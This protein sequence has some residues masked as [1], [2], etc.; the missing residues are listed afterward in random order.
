MIHFLFYHFLYLVFFLQNY[1]DLFS[2]SYRKSSE[3]SFENLSENTT[4]TTFETDFIL[5]VELNKKYVL[6]YGADLKSN[7]FQLFPDSNYSHL[8]LTRLKVGLKI[9]YSEK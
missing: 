1:I 6:I 3:T 8:Y 4:I 9:T 5:P 7:R 2:I